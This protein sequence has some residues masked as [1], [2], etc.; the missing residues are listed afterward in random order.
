MLIGFLMVS[1]EKD[2]V[3][4]TQPVIDLVQPVTESEYHLGDTIPFEC[5]F[6]DETEL[7]AYK[8]EI[9]YGEDHEHE[10]A[11][12]TAVTVKSDVTD[13]GAEWSYSKTADF[14]AGETYSTIILLDIIVP[15]SIEH[16]GVMEPTLEGEYHIGVYCTD[17]AGN[18]SE[19][20]TTID[21]GDHDH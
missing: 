16:D 6:S 21:V 12:L 17:A 5:N 4:N 15:D 11:T 13:E 8:V 10:S 19:L 3:D 1:C 20:F 2:E 18:Q 14:V 7:N 9:H